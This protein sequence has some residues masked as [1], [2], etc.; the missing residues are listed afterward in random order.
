MID[1]GLAAVLYWRKERW[2]NRDSAGLWLGQRGF[3]RQHVV[4]CSGTKHFTL[5]VSLHPGVSKGTDE[6][7]GRGWGVTL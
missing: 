5:S 2:S 4:S 1:G 7:D 6:C 3:E